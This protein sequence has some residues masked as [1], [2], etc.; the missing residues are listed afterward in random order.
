MGIYERRQRKITGYEC[1][2]YWF[3]TTS[4]LTLMQSG[5]SLKTIFLYF[6]IRLNASSMNKS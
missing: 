6:M 1:V 4:K 2:T 3:M 5:L